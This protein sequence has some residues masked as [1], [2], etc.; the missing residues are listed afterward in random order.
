MWA[1][2]MYFRRHLAVCCLLWV[3]T[4]CSV[5]GADDV[6]Q[7]PSEFIKEIFHGEL[8]KA[9]AVTLTKKDQAEIKGFMGNPYGSARVR[10]WGG[11][12]AHRLDTQRYWQNQTH[13]H[14]VCRVG[15]SHRTGQS[16]HIPGKSWMG[17]PPEILRAP[18]QG[19][20]AWD[21]QQTGPAHRQD[22]GS[23]PL[24][25]GPDGHGEA[26]PLPR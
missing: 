16:A 6:Y 20:G 5:L 21:R 2:G 7:K 14:G 19:C 15:Q 9:G 22:C 1:L 4:V 11:W 3:G 23:Y 17:S 12:G 18:I 10:F 13:H 26:C 24:V 8:P 25:T